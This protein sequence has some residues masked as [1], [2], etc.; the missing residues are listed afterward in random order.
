MAHTNER[1]VAG[2]TSGRIELGETVT[3]RARHFG[4][5]WSLTSRITVADPPTRFED[6]QVRGP[7]HAFRHEHRFETVP[8]GTLMVDDWEHVA[9]F[10]PL[11][12]LAD[13]L[14]LERHMRA[15]LEARNQTLKTEAEAEAGHASD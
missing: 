11:G 9:P 7:F 14:V 10:G 6:V 8:T 15:L 2:R 1:A 5:T 13:R 12:R 3:W 4:I